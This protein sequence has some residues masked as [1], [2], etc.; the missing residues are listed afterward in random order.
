MHLAYQGLSTLELASRTELQG[1]QGRGEG[2]PRALPGASPL[3]QMVLPTFARSLARSW[4]AGA[5][6]R[7]V[8]GLVPG[9][10]QMFGDLSGLACMWLWQAGFDC[11]PC[12]FQPP[13][14]LP[15]KAVIRLARHLLPLSRHWA[16]APS[17]PSSSLRARR[18]HRQ[19]QG[20]G[21]VHPPPSAQF[22]LGWQFGSTHMALD[23]Q[24]RG[25]EQDRH[26]GSPS[27]NLPSLQQRDLGAFV[28]LFH[29]I[30]KFAQLHLA[31]CKFLPS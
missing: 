6:S 30:P 20:H 7:S 31:K 25:R 22:Q 11:S 19:L 26:M 3:L 23:A 27:A 9:M 8:P 12:F 2:Q 16:G 17:L 13:S 4:Q 10:E 14:V 29:P 28:A 5:E 21:V 1:E 24:R 18:S 15:S